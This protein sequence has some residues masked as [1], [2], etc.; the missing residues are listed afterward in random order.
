METKYILPTHGF[1]L[2]VLS[3]ALFI[4]IL[5]YTSKAG[6]LI[7]YDSILAS[8]VEIIKLWSEMGKGFTF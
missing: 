1:L 2:L 7:S 4:W 8:L 5:R 6:S 3:G